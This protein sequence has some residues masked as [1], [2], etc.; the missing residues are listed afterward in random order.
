MSNNAITIKIKS[1]SKKAAYQRSI[2]EDHRQLFALYDIDF[3]AA[4]RIAAGNIRV[5]QNTAVLERN[6]KAAAQAQK[7]LE[8]IKRET[9]PIPGEKNPSRSLYRKIAFATHPDRQGVLDNSAADAERN[10]D[11]FKRAMAAHN[12]KD[13]SELIEIALE[14]GI[15]PLAMGYT[16]TD[17]KKIYDELEKKIKSQI[18]EI[19]NSYAWVWGESEGNI[20]LRINLLDNYLRRTGHPP[21]DKDI[22]RDIIQHHESDADKT[23]HPARTRKVGTRPKKLIR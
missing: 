6:I 20:A 15:D 1:W 22:L 4:L 17:L 7:T 2:L 16:P 12:N 23:V 3:M 21:V 14:L 13:K 11:L 19:E 10:E 8:D 5:K 18:T 9:A